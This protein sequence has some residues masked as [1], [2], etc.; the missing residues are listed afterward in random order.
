MRK[1]KLFE[2]LLVIMI[3][4]FFC[5]LIPIFAYQGKLS[6]DIIV[7]LLSVILSWPVAIITIVLVFVYKFRD[8]INYF[9]KN[10]G[11]M[12]LPGGVEIQSQTPSSSESEGSETDDTLKLTSQ[13]QQYLNKYLKELESAK[14]ASE[15][16]R[17][18]YKELYDQ[19]LYNAIVWKF[20]YL[21]MFFVPNTKLIL[22]WFAQ[23]PFKN[24]NSYH[25]AWQTNIQSKEQREIILNVLK[26]NGMIKVSEGTINV[27]SE[28]YAFLEYIGFLTYP[29]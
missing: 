29:S 27:T 11:S 6:P 21:N 13:E 5:L 16:E 2:I 19:E 10:I 28:G 26:Q 15:E 4:G 8:S 23:N 18:V 7:K 14:T 12:K 3:F 25:T 17:D 22:L 20:K 1:F 9:L 24:R